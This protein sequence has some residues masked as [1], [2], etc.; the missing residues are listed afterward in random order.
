MCAGPNQ[1]QGCIGIPIPFR[2]ER[3]L[4]MRPKESDIVTEDENIKFPEYV[5]EPTQVALA[6]VKEHVW[7]LIWGFLYPAFAFNTALS[8]I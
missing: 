7:F 6:E 2:H 5:T 1:K 8:D 4:E 3:V